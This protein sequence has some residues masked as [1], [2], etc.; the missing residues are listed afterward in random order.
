MKAHHTDPT[1]NSEVLNAALSRNPSTKDVVDV[2]NG[3][4]NQTGIYRNKKQKKKRRICYYYYTTVP[5]SDVDEIVWVDGPF[6]AISYV[7]EN[8]LDD[9]TIFE[10]V[11]RIIKLGERENLT[12]DKA[13]YVGCVACSKPAQ[14]DARRISQVALLDT[15]GNNQLRVSG[16]FSSGATSNC[17]HCRRGGGR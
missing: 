7:R 17:Y 4:L 13:V 11:S 1:S 6:I 3:A 5:G 8:T 15:K 14:K 10:A 16:I 2:K 9:K 12:L